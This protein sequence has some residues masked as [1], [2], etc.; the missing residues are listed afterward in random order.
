MIEVKAQGSTIGI[1]PEAVLAVVP[2]KEGEIPVM[3]KC[4]VVLMGI[5]PLHLDEGV[6]ELMAAVN[7]ALEGKGKVIT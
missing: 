2:I 1:K 6:T 7:D 3:G 4:E 5:G